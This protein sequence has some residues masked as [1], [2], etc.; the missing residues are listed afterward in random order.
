MQQPEK[1][2]TENLI[3]ELD[4]MERYELA[5]SWA[6]AAKQ[7]AETTQDSEALEVWD[8]LN[9]RTIVGA[10]I[11]EG[12]VVSFF[13]EKPSRP[14][15]DYAVLTP[16]IKKDVTRLPD[17]DRRKDFAIG[18]LK[19]T[20]TYQEGSRAIYLPLSGF[21]NP[22]KG[23]ILLHEGKH[24]WFDLEKKIDRNA[25]DSFW[26]EEAR[27]FEFE[28]RLLN[29]LIGKPYTD[30]IA[31]VTGSIASQK[32]NPALL[33]ASYKATSQDRKIIS[34]GLETNDEKEIDFWIDTVV[35]FNAFW[36]YFQENS[37][38]PEGEFI[39]LMKSN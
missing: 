3:S 10:P 26:V 14:A 12:G 22:G 5:K 24:A 9:T 25:K 23:I 28:F 20:A 13:R 36:H 16:I 31:R 32:Q 35:K 17:K 4:M 21:Q 2:N 7:I 8:F 33:N 6:L 19:A 11:P 18:N 15:E 34:K 38:D 29:L 37:S 27:V 1:S 39:H 30:L